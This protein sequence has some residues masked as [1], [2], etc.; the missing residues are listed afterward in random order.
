M[1]KIKLVGIAGSISEQS[2]NRELLYYI[3]HSFKDLFDFEVL[4]IKDLP[5][6]NQDH[7]EVLESFEFQEIQ[8]KIEAADGVVIATPEHN[9]TV[10][11]PLKSLLEWLSFKIHPLK[12]KPVKIMGASYLDQGTSSAQMHLRQIL[13]SPGIDALVLPGQEFLLGNCQSAFDKVGN[14]IDQ[15]TA[16]Y[17]RKSMEV[18]VTYVLT[19]KP[20]NQSVSLNHEF[21]MEE[22]WASQLLQVLDRTSDDPTRVYSQLQA[23]RPIVE[24]YQ[25]HSVDNQQ[26]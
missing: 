14:I 9:R 16:Q 12:A 2:Y 17:L 21:Q 1:V 5:L 20:L 10:P 6:F 11:A 15:K 26:L 4:D 25:S 7:L 22:I 13:E 19:L 3:Q 24:W 18:F 8:K 23:I